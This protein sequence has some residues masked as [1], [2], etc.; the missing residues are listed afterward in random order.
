M[1]KLL[2]FLIV[3]NPV[4]L[5]SQDNEDFVHTFSIVARDSITGEMGVA[6]QSHFFSVGTVV[7]WAEAGV[8]VVATQA[9]TNRSYGPEGIKLLGQGKSPEEIINML[10]AADSGRD[11]RQ[12]AVMDSKGR[13]ASFTG[14]NCIQSAGNI[15]GQNFSVQGNFL[16]NDNVVTSM[17]KAFIMSAGT[18]AER[19]L[20]A[21]EA[22]QLAGGDVRGKQSASILVVNAVSSGKIWQDR[23][24]D[25]RVD[26][27]PEPIKELQRLLTIHAAYQHLKL[28]GRHENLDIEKAN[29]EYL[30]AQS[31]YPDNPEMFFWHAV[32]LVNSK[33]YQDALPIFSKVFSMDANWKKLIPRLILGGELKCSREEEKQ[34]LNL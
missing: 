12:L 3:L 4:L 29:E 20:K 18:L 2:V 30:L 5:L 15:S 19:M 34:I 9:S 33:K 17:V 16:M 28:A 24:I 11:N 7:G 13:T 26:D 14:K 1:K 23:K 22:G 21:L 31:L 8:G 6:V 27:H 25:L 10:T 32:A